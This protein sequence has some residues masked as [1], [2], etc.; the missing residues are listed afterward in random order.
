MFNFRSQRYTK[1]CFPIR[2]HSTTT[3][4]YV[5][6]T[7]S[8]SPGHLTVDI[9]HDTTF[10]T[11]LCTPPIPGIIWVKNVRAIVVCEFLMKYFKRNILK[12]WKKIVGALWELLA[13]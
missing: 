6:V 10:V 1:T 9:L 5:I 3:W 4:M 12:I 13:K 8:P 7:L 2:G 11:L